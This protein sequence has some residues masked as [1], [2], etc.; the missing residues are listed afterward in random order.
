[1]RIG[2]LTSDLGNNISNGRIISQGGSAT[3]PVTND[4]ITFSA[5]QDDTS[6]SIIFDLQ[7][8]IK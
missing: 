4:K 1:M 3:I 7:G 2:E 6:D 8:Y 5:G